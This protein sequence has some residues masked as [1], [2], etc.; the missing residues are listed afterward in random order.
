MERF[1]RIKDGQPFEHPIM[2]ENFRQVFPDVDVNNLPEWAMRFE[3]DEPPKFEFYTVYEGVTYEIVN[4][5]C[6]GVY[7]FRPMTA[8]EKTAKIAEA[9]ALDHPD[10]WV[11]S[12]EHCSWIPPSALTT[13]SGTEPNVI[14]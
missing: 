13:N 12:E 10:D 4:G 3:Q 9:M 7:Q 1:I 6:K 8:E 14:G 2:G 11:F 5:I